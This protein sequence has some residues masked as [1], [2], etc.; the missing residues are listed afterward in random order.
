M[1]STRKI[2]RKKKTV[3][4]FCRYKVPCLTTDTETVGNKQSN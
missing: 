2:Q 1:K 3:Y 4:S